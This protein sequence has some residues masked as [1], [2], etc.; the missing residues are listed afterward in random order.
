MSEWIDCPL[1][2]IAGALRNGDL[3]ARELAEE[4]IAR[5]EK[6]DLELGAYKSWDADYARRQADAADIAFKKGK[7]LGPAQG[8]LF[9][10]K[11]IYGAKGFPV[12]A[13]SPKRLPEEWEHDGPVVGE[14][15]GQLAVIPGKTHTVEFA[16]GGLGT[17]PH[18]GTPRNP[19]DSQNHRV[20]GGSSSGA[21]VSL[22]EGSALIA[23]GTDTGGSVRV[24]ASMTGNVGLK[25]TKGRWSTD[26]ITILSSS[27]DTPGILAKS[28]S[29]IAFGFN[30]IDPAARAIPPPAIEPRDTG[31]ITIGLTKDYF[32]KRCTDDVGQVV[33]SAITELAAVGA[34][35]TTITLPEVDPAIQLWGEGAVVA[36]EGYGFLQNRLPDWI[37]SLDPNVLA[38][39]EVSKKAKTLDYISALYQISDLSDSFHAKLEQVD[40][41]AVPTVPI[42]PPKVLDVTNPEAYKK[43]NLLALSNTMPVNVLGGCA[44]TIPVGLD[45][46]GMPVGMQIIA[47]PNREEDLIALALG[48][49]KKIG[50]PRDRLGTP[51]LGG[52]F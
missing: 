6:W 9:S 22:W 41:L 25:T 43:L 19:W 35:L 29:D 37:N 3:S 34:K 8:I 20:P 49:E 39:M 4:G 44:I 42:T 15:R 2:E 18:W 14:V 7:D 32:W 5:H 24:P 38:R 21:G 46:Y 40:A 16:F 33:E 31:N 47:P 28:V 17:N 51:P 26:L 13:G 1:S 36:S 10:I 45:K 50:T 30:S 12:F 11:D 52:K 48:I 27:F 23:F